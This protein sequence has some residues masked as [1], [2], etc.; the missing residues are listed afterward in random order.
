MIFAR[1][2]ARIWT[3]MKMR[4][5]DADALKDNISNIKLRVKNPEIMSGLVEMKEVAL[6]E[7]EN[8]QTVEAEPVRHGKWETWGYMLDGILWK[9]CN[10]C[11]MAA[12]I[13]Y[14]GFQNGY[15]GECA[16]SPYCAYCGAK[17]DGGGDDG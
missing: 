17:M 13:S 16:D 7:I 11:G 8:A 1:T 3:V 6:R 4:L 10:S 9:R 5:I 14:Q 15:Y 12:N 2:A